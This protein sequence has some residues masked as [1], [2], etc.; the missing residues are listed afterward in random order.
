MELL[1]LP[2]SGKR[3]KDASLD[4]YKN[5]EDKVEKFIVKRMEDII[6]RNSFTQQPETND[7][8]QEIRSI[9]QIWKSVA[10]KCGEDDK[11]YFGKKFMMKTPTNSEKRLLKQFVSENEDDGYDEISFNTPTSMRNVDSPVLGEILIWKE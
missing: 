6:A 4:P 9:I 10:D 2:S 8:L 3:K 7:I 1:W 5:I 11:L